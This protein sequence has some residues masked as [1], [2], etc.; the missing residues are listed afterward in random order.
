M[1][2]SILSNYAGM[3]IT[4]GVGILMTPFMIH[5][6][7]DFH[8]GVWIL[9][10]SVLDYYGLADVG[11]RFTL[12]RHVACRRGNDQREALSSLLV[13]TLAV[14]V[15][16]SV[17]ILFITVI[18]GHTLPL[19]F[20]LS[21]SES[22]VFT[23]AIYLLGIG[24]AI[25]FPA[26]IIGAYICGLQRFDLFNL[27]GSS[28]TIVQ[29]GLLFAVILRGYDIVGCAAVTLV[30]AVFSVVTQ[31]FLLRIADPGLRLE[32]RLANLR[33]LRELFGFGFHVSLY[34]VGD[35]MRYRLDSFVIARWLAMPLVTHFNVAARLAE[36]FRYITAGVAGPLVTEM[37]T[38]QGQSGQR[39]MRELLMRATKLTALLCFLVCALLCLNGKELLTLWVGKSFIGSYAVLVTLLV[40]QTVAM[41]QSPSLGLLLARG[42]HR[43]LAT[44]TVC[45]GLANLV[46]SIYWAH[47]YGILGVA[48]GTAVPMLVFKVL[49]QP[50]YT[51]H[52]AALPALDYLKSFLRPLVVVAGFL[53]AV[54]TIQSPFPQ[55]RHLYSLALTV[56]WQVMIYLILAYAVGFN[57]S[58]RHIVRRGARKLVSARGLV[59][60]S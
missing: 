5:H 14:G 43:A 54:T 40:S 23:E 55:S 60:A 7:G 38:L 56:L 33:D 4:A 32:S 48:M 50:W 44:W 16:A 29:A 12:Q 34:Q 1:F 21:G 52:V 59:P 9:A 2:R 27:A 58:D 30:T 37:S 13:T 24:F 8:Y 18:L 25:G 46:L 31:L 19:V 51:L 3:V 26:K 49:V 6:L 53:A 35:L 22:A 42:K 11:M 10:A 36:Y 15:A 28:A 45:E 39:Q 57:A 20:R 41:V 47:R 17:V